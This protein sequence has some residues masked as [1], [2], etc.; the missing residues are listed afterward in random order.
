MAASKTEDS[1]DS[2]FKG[3]DSVLPS[4]NDGASKTSASFV[5][6]LQTEDCVLLHLDGS[7]PEVEL[8]QEEIGMQDVG[9][10]AEG[11]TVNIEERVTRVSSR[12]AN[13]NAN[14]ITV[15]DRARQQAAFRDLEGTNLNSSNS[16][17]VLDFD[18]IHARA[19]EMG[20]DPTSFT[21]EKVDIMKYLEIARHNLNKKMVGVEAEAN[22][23][24]R[25]VALLGAGEDSIDD[26]GFTPVVSKSSQKKIKAARRLLVDGLSSIN[27]RD[28]GGAQVGCSAASVKVNNNHPVSGVVAGSR[29]RKKK[30]KVFMIGASL[31]CRDVGKKGMS[32]FLSDFIKE[33]ML[34][35]IGLQ[36]TIK[37]DYS[38]AFFRKI[39]PMNR[40]TWK[41]SASVGR[42]GG[43]YS[44][45]FQCSQIYGFDLSVQ[46]I[47]CPG[48]VKRFEG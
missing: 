25:Q 28:V 35:F 44:G 37:K 20:V 26:E 12:L 40:F 32:T 6:Q 46:Q 30:P 4:K 23:N 24:N 45:W 10:N 15:E 13:Q 19:L 21:L 41:W 5:G 29:I 14:N 47:F 36:E 33:Q 31:N 39:D 17:A 22:E 16:F 11:R 38:Q 18:D 1:E 34:D 8:T 3:D 43:I 7:Q 2:F 9:G 48:A 27:C 42:A